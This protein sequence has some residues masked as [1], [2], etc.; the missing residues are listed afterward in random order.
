MRRLTRRVPKLKQA[1]LA[2]LARAHVQQP[3]FEQASQACLAFWRS[4]CTAQ[5]RQDDPFGVFPPHIHEAVPALDGVLFDT[6]LAQ[7]LLLQGPLRRLFP[8]AV[9]HNG[10]ATH[11][12][13]VLEA[14]DGTMQSMLPYLD[15]IEREVDATSYEQRQ[16]LLTSLVQS[17]LAA[18]D[19]KQAKQRC[20]RYTAPEMVAFQCDS[21]EDTLK[22][23]YGRTLSDC[24]VPIL[25]PC[26]GTGIF[27]IA[28]MG[29]IDRGALPYK[30]HHELFG[31][32]IML[33]PYY[34]ASLNIEQC[35]AELA[36]AYESFQ[37]IRYAD[38]LG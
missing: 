2:N 8:I 21:V 37:G 23:D 31:I 4:H 36:G 30:Y 13:S 18:W 25:D 32:E 34:I 35:Y 22:R 9:Q 11:L 20:A 14:L 19:A 7:V 1:L 26:T 38:A 15:D 3:H 28:I 24:S 27:L 10:L 29:H 16:L 5:Y 12:A 17:F 33:L 6:L